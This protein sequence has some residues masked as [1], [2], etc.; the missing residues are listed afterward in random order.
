LLFGLRVGCGPACAIA[1]ALLG[2]LPGRVQNRDQLSG[3]ALALSWR[4]GEADTMARR[5]RDRAH[6]PPA[7]NLR[8]VFMP[9][10]GCRCHA[11]QSLNHKSLNHQLTNR[12]SQRPPRFLFIPDLLSFRVAKCPLRPNQV[13]FPSNLDFFHFFPSLMKSNPAAPFALYSYTACWQL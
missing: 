11:F 1:H 2:V 13:F 7:R 9:E 5:L 4:E 3:A 8:N 10:L 12:A 6:S